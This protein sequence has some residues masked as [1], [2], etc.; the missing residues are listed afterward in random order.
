MKGKTGNTAHRKGRKTQ[1]DYI[2]TTTNY[3]RSKKQY[4]YRVRNPHS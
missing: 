2:Q 1:S 3:P 4:R